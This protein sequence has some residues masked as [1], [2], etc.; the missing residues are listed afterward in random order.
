MTSSSSSLSWLFSTDILSM[1]LVG[2]LWGCTNPL[3]RKGSM[4]TVSSSSSSTNHSAT[5]DNDKNEKKVSLSSLLRSFLR[6]QVWL[7]Y[8][9]NQSGSIVFY[10]LLSKSSVDLSMA[11]PICN[12]LALVFTFVTSWYVLGEPMHKPVQTIVGTVL[13]MVGVTICVQSSSTMKEGDIRAAAAATI[14]GTTAQVGSD[15]DTINEL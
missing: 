14:E 6:F 10:L 1:L 3:L 9:L 2:A 12:A 11:V 8:A 13:I 4:E 7:P 15:D 5:T